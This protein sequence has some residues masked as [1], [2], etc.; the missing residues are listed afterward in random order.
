MEGK[1]GATVQVEGVGEVINVA[2]MDFLGMATRDEI[3]K[4]AEKVIRQAGVGSC[5]PRGFYGTSELHLELERELADFLGTDGTIVYPYDE[6]APGSLLSTFAKRGDLIVCDECASFPLRSGCSLSRAN[7]VEFRHND[8]EHLESILSEAL[9]RDCKSRRFT[10]RRYVVVEGFYADM[11]DFCQ[12]DAVLS[13]KERYRFRAVV[14]DSIGMGSVAKRGTFE[15]FGVDVNRADMLICS[16]S[17]ALG[18]MGAF[19]AGPNKVI[20]HQRINSS[21]YVFSAS[22]PP[23]LATAARES[24]SILRSAEGDRLLASL[25]DNA[26]AL[27]DALHERLPP[28]VCLV[29]TRGCPVLFL[30]VSSREERP[31]VERARGR[32]LH[33]FFTLVAS[34]RHSHLEGDRAPLPGLRLVASSLHTRELLLQG[35]RNACTA[36]ASELEAFQ[37]NSRVTTEAA[38]P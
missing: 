10:R 16:M 13:L 31:A 35:A 9:E 12:L 23:F 22:L 4:S 21:G 32:L 19:C 3:G 14:D 25:R 29:G 26:E 20:D 8:M 6:A 17:C 1:P 38:L 15:L 2:T 30:R 34:A 33:E 7:V 28:G 27:Y 11:A 24:L 5:G 36:L 37:A 18:S